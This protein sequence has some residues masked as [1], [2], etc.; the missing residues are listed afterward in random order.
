MADVLNLRIDP[1]GLGYC[2][3]CGR[4]RHYVSECEKANCK[5]I[6]CLLCMER[7]LADHDPGGLGTRPSTSPENVV[8]KGGPPMS[9][10]GV[11]GSAKWLIAAILALAVL[12]G[13]ILQS[14]QTR[15]AVDENDIATLRRDLLD[16]KRGVD[17]LVKAKREHD[18]R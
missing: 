16:I 5:A 9:F 2:D 8:V 13:G 6:R 12:G 15:L 4:S 10:G 1:S 18:T 7:H 14:Q 17:E 11:N 3:G